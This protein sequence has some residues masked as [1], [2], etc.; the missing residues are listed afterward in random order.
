M[1]DE[2]KQHIKE[3]TT[4]MR[5]LYM[6]LF[7][8]FYSV[9]KVIV[10]AVIVFQFLMSLVTGKTNERLVILGQ[11][12]STYL[13]QILTFLTFN[14]DEHPYPFGAWPNGE[15]ELRKA[16]TKSTSKKSGQEKAIEAKKVKDEKKT[17][18]E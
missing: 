9:A 14:S 4:W 15:P 8:V 11:S 2:I 17:D 16:A 12:L 5:G 18:S 1:D 10:F 7:L 3:K 13:Y 6:L